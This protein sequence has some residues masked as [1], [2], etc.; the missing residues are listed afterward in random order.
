MR[1]LFLNNFLKASQNTNPKADRYEY[2][3]TVDE[4]L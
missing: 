1:L 3:D 2:S 4:W